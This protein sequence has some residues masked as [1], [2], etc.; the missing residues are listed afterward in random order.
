M[1][2]AT[3]AGNLAPF[4]S[5]VGR[6]KRPK[7]APLVIT[8]A[9]PRTL[10]MSIFRDAI[11]RFRLTEQQAKAS[12]DPS[13]HYLAIE[14]HDSSKELLKKHFNPN[15]KGFQVDPHH[16]TLKHDL[17]DEDMAWVQKH[18]DQ[19][20]NMRVTH[21]ASEPGLHAVRVQPIGRRANALVQRAGK[22]HP[23][24][25]VAFD[26]SRAKPAQSNDLLAKQ[27]GERLK[28]FLH[29]GGTVRLVPKTT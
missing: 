20:V 10:T 23:H 17:S 24:V 25:T 22:E 6:G 14:L 26:P 28:K 29:I 18:L 1:D 16:V 2:E 13:K 12:V 27:P 15:E 19:N 7:D 8:R 9:R 3:L 5:A 11:N 21:R 4:M